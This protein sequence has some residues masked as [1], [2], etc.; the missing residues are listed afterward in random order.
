[1]VIRRDTEK[2][3]RKILTDD[4]VSDWLIERV[5]TLFN[6]QCDASYDSGLANGQEAGYWSAID[7][8]NAS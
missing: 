5:L 2:E 8:R 7:M 6:D 3:I 1:M 4:R